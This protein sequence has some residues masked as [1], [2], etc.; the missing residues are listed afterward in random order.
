MK[1]PMRMRIEENVDIIGVGYV[2]PVTLSSI[3]VS[4][5]DSGAC[6]V[7][8]FGGAE[9]HMSLLLQLQLRLGGVSTVQGPSVPLQSS[10]LQPAFVMFVPITLAWVP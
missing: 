5:P 3:I 6:G 2:E 1:N 4:S 9:I 8:R 7:K 10:L